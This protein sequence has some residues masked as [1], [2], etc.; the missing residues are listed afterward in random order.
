MRLNSIY[1]LYPY[2][3]NILVFHFL[4][5]TT[6]ALKPKVHNHQKRLQQRRLKIELKSKTVQKIS[7]AYNSLL[8]RPHVKSALGIIG[9]SVLT[10]KFFQS[11]HILNN[12]QRGNFCCLFLWDPR[13]RINTEYFIFVPKIKFNKNIRL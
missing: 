10:G 4:F 2:P 12:L 8:V 1:H 7:C 5:G 6:I 9:I 3:L 11:F 13:L